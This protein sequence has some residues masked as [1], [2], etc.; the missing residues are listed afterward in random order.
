MFRLRVAAVCAVLGLAMAATGFAAGKKP[1]KKQ[2]KPVQQETKQA[3]KSDA[4]MTYADFETEGVEYG[5]W[6]KDP[7]DETQGCKMEIAEPGLGDKGQAVKLEYD[8]DSPNEAFN[9]FW[10][11][12][13][14][15]DLSKYGKLVLWVKG[16]KN[17]G[18][19]KKIKI[20]IKNANESSAVYA[21]DITDVWSAIEVP[22]KDFD[23]ITDWSKISEFV[24][25]FDEQ[26]TGDTAKTGSICIDNISFA[27]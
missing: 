26:A 15:A 14:N 1:P 8:I 3:P 18:Y 9:G 6:N 10:M 4:V 5:V 12:L 11:K 22:F 20:E 23:K 16:D 19:T 24:V 2:A 13:N 27:K 21:G 17:A 7:E 25:V